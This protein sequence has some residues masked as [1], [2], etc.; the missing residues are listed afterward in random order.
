MS[1]NNSIKIGTLDSKIKE[2]TEYL[3]TSVVD[4]AKEE[5]AKLIEEGEQEKQEII[6][7]AK[8]EA[9]KIIKNAQNEA[10]TLKQN[11]E[12]ALKIAAKQAMDRVKLA[13][14][15]EI[16]NFTAKEPVKQA[17][18]SDEVIK[19]FVSE[20]IK[21]YSESNINF[22]ITLGEDVKASVTSFIEQEIKAKGLKGIEISKDSLPS[23]FSISFAENSLKIDFTEESVFELFTEYLR[24]ELRESLFKK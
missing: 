16:L 7:K 3:K 9:E 2:I 24:P 17:M 18:K 23:G 1:E 6:A 19:S 22:A 11:T 21:Q 5:K 8:E 4:P 10:Q 15:K 14:E 20:V 12:S 13:I